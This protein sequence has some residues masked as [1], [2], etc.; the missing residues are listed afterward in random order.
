MAVLSLET[1]LIRSY[2]KTHIFHL[3]IANF[4]ITIKTI[5]GNYSIFMGC[6]AT[7]VKFNSF[8]IA[9]NCTLI[10]YFIEIN[11]ETSALIRPILCAF[12]INKTP[13]IISFYVY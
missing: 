5:H 11:Y 13:S 2:I 1:M 7:K 10:I 4:I 8:I 9:F 6:K 3:T 12:F